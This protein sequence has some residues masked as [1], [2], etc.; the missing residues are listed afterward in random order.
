M[1]VLFPGSVLKE[2]EF[3]EFF[4]VDISTESILKKAN[5]ITGYY[6][7]NRYNNFNKGISLII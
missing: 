4:Q 2:N 6:C 3:E 5:E 1:A 7:Q